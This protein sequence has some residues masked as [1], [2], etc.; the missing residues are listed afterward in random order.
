MWYIRGALL[1]RA[2]EMAS[3]GSPGC[4]AIGA[5]VSPGRSTPARTS[6]RLGSNAGKSGRGS[7]HDQ[8]CRGWTGVELTQLRQHH[9][10]SRVARYLDLVRMMPSHAS[11]AN[12]CRHISLHPAKQHGQESHFTRSTLQA[13]IQLVACSDAHLPG[14]WGTLVT[15]RS[16]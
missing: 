7:H 8:R 9:P 3:T 13:Q 6:T 14:E 10:R 4:T 12:A 15:A 2:L 11:M 1:A 5:L 16:G